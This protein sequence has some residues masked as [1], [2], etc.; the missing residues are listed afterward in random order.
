MTCPGLLD[1]ACVAGVPV[2]AERNIG[3][4]RATRGSFPI[5]DARKM[6]R[7]QKSSFL[8]SPHF[9]RVLNAKTPSRSPKRPYISFT[10]YGNACYAG[11]SGPYSPKNIASVI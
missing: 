3:P 1:L 4:L 11:N 8:L 2:R 9:P 7:E 10:S 5:Q 6:G